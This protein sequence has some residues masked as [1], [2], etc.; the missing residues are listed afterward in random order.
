[1]ILHGLN[2]EHF[3]NL[4]D[5][6]NLENMKKLLRQL[7][8]FEHFENWLVALGASYRAI[9]D[10]ILLSLVIYKKENNFTAPSLF[11]PTRLLGTLE[12]LP[13]LSDFTWLWK[14]NRV[15]AEWLVI[16]TKIDK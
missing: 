11:G 9:L 1:M 12:Y 6:E 2:F 14:K 16:K 4:E 7:S 3:K 5:L 15:M 8:F 13:A 10:S